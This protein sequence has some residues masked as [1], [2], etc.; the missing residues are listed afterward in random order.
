MYLRYFFS[1]FFG[2][3]LVA[4]SFLKWHE[5]IDLYKILIAL[6]FLRSGLPCPLQKENSL[7]EKLISEILENWQYKYG[8]MMDPNMQ[9][10]AK[11]HGSFLQ[12][13]SCFF[14]VYF[15]VWWLNCVKNSLC[16]VLYFEDFIVI[17][18]FVVLIWRIPLIRNTQS[19]WDQYFHFG[20]SALVTKADRLA[21]RSMWIR[22]C[23]MTATIPW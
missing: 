5:C 12:I 11:T 4:S 16:S 8:S 3:N 6:C 22:L 14:N 15:I 7:T 9:L 1:R 21:S 17:L 13:K 10:M 20:C 19:I 2:S 18:D 23:M